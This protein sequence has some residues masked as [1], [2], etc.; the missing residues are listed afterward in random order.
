MFKQ[1]HKVW[2][3]NEKNLKQSD[4]VAKLSMIQ[5]KLI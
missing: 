3:I 4:L 5:G 2:E 1:Q